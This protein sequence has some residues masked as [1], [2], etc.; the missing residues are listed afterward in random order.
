VAKTRRNPQSKQASRAASAA[1]PVNAANPAAR[2]STASSAPP[3]PEADARAAERIAR[4]QQRAAERRRR[5]RQRQLSIAA[6]ALAAVLVIG[7]GVAWALT[8]ATPAP[9]GRTVPIAS[10]E[11]I[12]DGQKATDHNSVPPT[13]GQHYQ[14]PA[15]EGVHES[16]I[17]NEVQ[18]HN[19]E[20]G[21]IMVQYTCTD[22][23]EL[24]AQLT[25]F[26]QRYRPRVL[27]APYPDAQVG[28]RIALTAWGRIDTFDEFD[29]Q[30]IVAFIE[31]YR[32]K[33]PEQVI[34]P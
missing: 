13:S 3:R 30:R 31:A 25:P 14:N 28:A 21:Q 19:L 4:Q 5:E 32:N 34:M 27:V 6:M 17:S 15:R 33:G 20:H 7:G 1:R 23:P 10:R 8:R 29:E 11:H 22:C 2:A 26:A 24:V 9:Q 12:S 16:P 18:V